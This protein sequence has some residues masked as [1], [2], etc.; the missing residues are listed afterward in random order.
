ELLLSVPNEVWSLNPASGKLNWYAETKVDTGAC[1]SLVAADD[2]AYV[3]GGRRGGRTAVRIG[4]KSDVTDS[5]VL[6]SE[7]GGSYVPSPVFHQGHLY[8]INDW[9]IASCSH[10]KTG[11]VVTNQRLD[12][13]FYS[14][15]VLIADKL[16]AVSRFDGTY[17]LKATP[18][19]EQIALNKL[20]DESDFSGSPAV[21]DGQ[22]F[23]RSEESLY[24][25]AAE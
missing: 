12:G 7:N 3:I 23:I 21:S 13:R 19:F 6:W 22:L 1:C 25:V 2:I 11:N 15:V 24:C 18:E 14:S 8:W 10:T 16:Y 5:N 9:V 4:G 20:S 17:V